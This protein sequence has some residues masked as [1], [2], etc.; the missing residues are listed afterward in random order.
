MTLE[1]PRIHMG[2]GVSDLEA[3]I[4]FY[5]VLLGGPPTKVRPRYARFEPADPSVNLALVEQADAAAHRGHYG[6]QVTSPEAVAEATKRLQEAGLDTRGEEASACCY[7]VQTK[8][9]VADPDGNRWE[10]FVTLDDDAA[11]LSPE[12]QCCVSEG[13]G[14]KAKCC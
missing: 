1:H 10:I 14:A 7:A 5:S 9:W 2:L 12:G 4:A 11:E 8:T 6:I 3:S 13:T